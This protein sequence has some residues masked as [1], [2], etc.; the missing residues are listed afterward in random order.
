[1]RCA[2]MVSAL[3]L[4]HAQGFVPT[5]R[6]PRKLRK[7]RGLS[8]PSFWK[9]V[10]PPRLEE[11]RGGNGGGRPPNP[12][13]GG[14]DEESG[15]GRKEE[16]VALPPGENKQMRGPAMPPFEYWSLMVAILGLGVG[17]YGIIYAKTNELKTIID[18]KTNEIKTG[19]RGL[20]T[21]G[22]RGLK[23]DM[24]TKQDLMATKQDLYFINVITM[25]CT[26]FFV[27]AT[28]TSSK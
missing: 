18:A 26:I 25:L 3:L 21:D 1:M 6:P 9:D 5:K 16:T 4:W 19:I 7:S 20:K 2:L 17:L 11:N 27:H 23:T 24:A 15:G 14:D 22:I 8:R 10:I 13:E 28:R 12:S